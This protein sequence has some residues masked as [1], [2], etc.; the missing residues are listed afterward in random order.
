MQLTKLDRW[1]KDR[2]A[3]ETHVQVLRLPERVPRGV[4]V[5]ELPDIPG[6]RFQFMLVVRRTGVADELFEILKEESMM[7]STQI[8]TRDAWYVKFVAPKE[9]SLTWSIVSWILILSAI[10]GVATVV[11]RLLQD[12]E[13]RENLKEA[14]EILKG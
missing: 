1:L 13:I 14:I 11:Y 8:I 4:K 10:I 7:Y 9:T 6:R 12:P 5:I 3:Y 2:F